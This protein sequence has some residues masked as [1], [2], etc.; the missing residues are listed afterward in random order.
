MFKTF[1]LLLIVVFS[2]YRVRAQSSVLDVGIRLQKA[3]NLYHEN[4]F[5]INYS[6]RNFK[7]DKVYFG[8]S[9]ITSRLGSAFNSNAIKQDN[10]LFSAGYYWR[11]KHVVRPFGR[12]NLGYFSA[13]YGDPIFDILPRKSLLASADAGSEF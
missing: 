1:C 5:T 2:G 11:Q 9:Y 4:G 8:F 10:F 3:V 7:P 6:N 12:F 13:N